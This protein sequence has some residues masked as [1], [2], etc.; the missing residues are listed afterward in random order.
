MRTTLKTAC[1]CVLAGALCAGYA[2]AGTAPDSLTG[3]S[4][5]QTIVEYSKKYVGTPYRYGGAGADGMDCSGFLYTVARESAGLTLPR[6]V[7]GIYGSVR[8]VEDAQ[9]EAGDILFFRTQGTVISHAALYIGNDQFIHAVSEGSSR[10]VIVSSLKDAYWKQ[11]YAGAGQVLPPSSGNTG[12][13]AGLPSAPGITPGANPKTPLIS[14]FDADA[15]LTADWTLF[16]TERFALISRGGS[17]LFHVSY[18]KWKIHPGIGAGIGYDPT[19][20]AFNIPIFVSF[21][22]G[23]GFRLYAGGMAALGSLRLPDT[24]K[25]LSQAFFP[26]ILGVSWQFPVITAARAGFALIQDVRYQVYYDS[27]RVALPPGESMAAG[28]VFSTG[29]RVSFFGN[30]W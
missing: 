22:P 11:R 6:T 23:A 29:I 18:K 28:L 20:G 2:A 25:A 4:S 19:T 10:G 26:G 3:E 9:K 27:D 1:W 8:A 17:A 7:S 21:S 5:R 15:T 16:S 30:E 12:A 14:A 24:D 13:G